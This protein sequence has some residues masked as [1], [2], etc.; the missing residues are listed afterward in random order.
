MGRLYLFGVCGLCKDVGVV[1]KYLMDVVN[2]GDVMVMVNLGN[3]YVNGFG[4][5]VDN[6]TALYWFRK[7][8]KK[9]NVMGWYGFGYMMFVGYGVV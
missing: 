5:D 9:G 4:V 7:A 8:V 2:V 1:C 3:M 6:V